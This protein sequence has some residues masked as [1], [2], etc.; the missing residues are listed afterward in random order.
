[1]P[2]Q[3]ANAERKHRISETWQKHLAKRL[4]IHPVIAHRLVFSMSKDQH[5][6]LTDAGINPD[7]VFHSTMKK[8]MRRFNRE[9]PSQRFDRIRVWPSSRH[10]EP[11]RLRRNLSAHR[12]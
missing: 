8:V 4:A 2:S 5:D 7:Q 12:K 10:A 3:L 9:I 11:P 1:M 6:A